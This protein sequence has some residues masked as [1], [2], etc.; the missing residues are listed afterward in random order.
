MGEPVKGTLEIQS[1]PGDLA[2][3][4]LDPNKADITAGGNG[5][6]GDL[7]LHNGTGKEVAR[8]GRIQEVIVDPQSPLSPG[9][10]RAA[11]RR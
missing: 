1:D 3:I 7:I 9:N 5:G 10:A 2:R 8:L 4:V 11:T 6:F